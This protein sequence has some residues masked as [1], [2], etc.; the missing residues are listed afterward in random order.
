MRPSGNGTGIASD[1]ASGP[2]AVD[3]R[4]T[5]AVGRLSRLSAEIHL[6]EARRGE[7]ALPF[8][9]KA[10][11]RGSRPSHPRTVH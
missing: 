2:A 3:G 10:V 7:A 6:V 11:V 9:V 8:R 4:R 5:F 1:A